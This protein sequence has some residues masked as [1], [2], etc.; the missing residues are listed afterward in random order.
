MWLGILA[1]VLVFWYPLKFAGELLATVPS[2]AM[3]GPMA[4]IELLAHAVVA[5]LSVAAGWSLYNRDTHGP[6]L[7]R[8]ALVLMAATTVQAVYWTRLP[9]QTPPGARW[10]LAVA[11]IAHTGLWLVYLQRSGRVRAIER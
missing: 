1:L 9:T 3:R 11:A 4:A 6:A 8:L 10:P 7:A 5:M 2:L